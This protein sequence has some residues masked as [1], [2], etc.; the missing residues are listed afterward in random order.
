MKVYILSEGNKE[1]GFGHVTRCMSIYQ[2][3]L[4]KRISPIFIINGDESTQTV[5]NGASPLLM[6]WIEQKEVLEEIY[7]SDMVIIDSYLADIPF[8]RTVSKIVKIPVYFDDIQRLEYP[9]GIVINGAIGAENISYPIR[10]DIHYLLGHRYSCLRKEF[11]RVPVKKIRKNIQNILFTFGGNDMRN[12]M[13]SVLSAVIR[14][15]PK[16]NKFI[17]AGR[18]FNHI[19]EIEKVKDE[20]TQIIYDPDAKTIRNLMQRADIAVTAGGQTLY[21]LAR[22]GVPSIVI[23][24]ADNQKN[25]ILGW[26]KMG[27]IEYA[28]SWHENNLLEKVKRAIRKIK[29]QKIRKHQ[30]EIGKKLINGKGSRLIVKTLLERLSA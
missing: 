14:E 26:L 2:A 23:S 3:F 30:S 8:Y 13:P 21:E 10:K 28:G 15:A 4:E 29:Y 1:T 27:F 6:N 18:A 19:E 25:N 7:G 22:M 24:V 5:W 11:W 12:L 17:V 16:I 20:Y 9:K